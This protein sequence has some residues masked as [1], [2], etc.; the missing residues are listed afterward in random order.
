MV[1]HV[2]GTSYD[3]SSSHGKVETMT[4]TGGVDRQGDREPEFRQKSAEHFA[5]RLQGIVDGLDQLSQARAEALRDEILEQ[6]TQALRDWRFTPDVPG[7]EPAYGTLAWKCKIANDPRSSRI[8][9][10]HYGT[11]HVSVL[12]YREQYGGIRA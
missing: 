10:G 4:P 8:V 9:A 6:T 2:R 7:V 12:R 5:R 11:S 1:S 3:T